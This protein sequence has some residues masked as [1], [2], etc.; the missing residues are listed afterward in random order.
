MKVTKA[1]R[2]A[3]WCWHYS[4]KVKGNVFDG[5][6]TGVVV[7]KLGSFFGKQRIDF[8]V[9]RDDVIKKCDELLFTDDPTVQVMVLRALFLLSARTGHIG[10]VAALITS[11]DVGMNF[12]YPVNNPLGK[13]FVGLK[14]HEYLDSILDLRTLNLCE[15]LQEKNAHWLG[16]LEMNR[17]ENDGTE[18]DDSSPEVENRKQETLTWARNDIRA[19]LELLVYTD[20]RERRIREVYEDIEKIVRYLFTQDVPFQNPT[21]VLGYVLRH[22]SFLAAQGYFSERQLVCI[23]E[24]VVKNNTCYWDRTREPIPFL[25]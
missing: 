2:D 1:Q 7:G 18:L 21:A 16:C 12:N 8:S 25:I 10:F 20:Y 14:A 15:T 22:L 9:T 24:D 23:V 11:R 5:T 4:S 13:D 6:L 3:A 19:Y 17:I